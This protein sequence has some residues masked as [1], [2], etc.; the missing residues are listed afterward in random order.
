MAGL[1]TD[2]PRQ[3]CSSS[4]I[5]IQRIRFSRRRSTIR[6]TIAEV[7]RAFLRREFSRRALRT[8]AWNDPQDLRTCKQAQSSASVEGGRRRRRGGRHRSDRW[9]SHRLGA[10]HQ[11]HHLGRGRRLLRRD[12]GDR[13]SGLQGP[14]LQ[15]RDAGRHRRRA[16][17]PLHHAA[18][19]HRREQHRR[20]QDGLSRGQGGAEADPGVEVQ[21]VGR[22][23]A[24]VH[25]ER[26]S[27]R[28][29]GVEPGFVAVQVHVLRRRGGQEARGQADRVPDFRAD[30]LQCRHARHSSRP[31][32]RPR[33]DHELEGL[34]RSQVQGQDRP[35]RLSRD[36]GHRC[37][38][39]ARS[40]RRAQVRRQGQH[41][42]GRGRQDRQDHDRSQ[43]GWPFP[44]VLDAP[45]TSR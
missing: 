35:G 5:S 10:E 33:Q 2:Y 13:R 4:R 42:Q 6:P 1:R 14:G 25:E 23:R 15:L 7:R 39:G 38:H 16:D 34:S 28:A 31:D 21:A 29:V 27:L 44:V 20:H 3:S 12:Q 11:G 41:D 19:H 18:Q 8:E 9:L 17:Q 24:A 43:E 32:R 30:D 22:H 36:R 37:R 45:S 26:L 40:A